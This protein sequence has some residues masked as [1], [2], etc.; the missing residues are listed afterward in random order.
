[1]AYWYNVNTNSVEQGDDTNSKSYLLGPYAT[2]DEARKAIDTAHAKSEA[3]DAA[4]RE[5]EGEN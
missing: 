2:E 4:D 5:F 3:W 1:M